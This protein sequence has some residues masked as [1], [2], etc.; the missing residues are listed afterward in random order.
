MSGTSILGLDLLNNEFKNIG[1]TSNG[2]IETNLN[3]SGNSHGLALESTLSSVDNKLIRGDDENR[4]D[5]L[6]VSL[7]ARHPNNVD[8]GLLHMTAGHNLKVSIEELNGT[9]DLATQTTLNELNLKVSKGGDAILSNAQQVLNYGCYNNQDLRP[10]KVDLSGRAIVQVDGVRTNG[11]QTINVPDGTTVAGATISMGNH[12]RIAFYGDTDNITNTNIFIEYSQDGVNWYR[13]A[14]D[15]AKI[16][17][18]SS[19]G[20]FYD[21]EHVTPPRVRISRPNTSGAAETLQLYYTLL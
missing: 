8:L 10:L 13:G 17:I 18:V 11:S 5:A 2:Y 9:A 6:E 15:N 19:T 16:I 7:Y 21:E 20:N 12:T 4:P 3:V 1:V 14:G